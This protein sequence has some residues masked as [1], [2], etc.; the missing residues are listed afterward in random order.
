MWPTKRQGEQIARWRQVRLDRDCFDLSLSW[1]RCSTRSEALSLGRARPPVRCLA[2]YQA[3]DPSQ[4]VFV[5]SRSASPRPSKS[6]DVPSSEAVTTLKSAALTRWSKEPSMTPASTTSRPTTRT[7]S[8]Q[9]CCKPRAGQHRR[10]KSARSARA[11]RAAPGCAP[12]VCP[13]RALTSHRC[14][15]GYEHK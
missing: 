6:H 5:R 14:E 13:Y 1:F 15:S 8:W 7:P 2:I 10:T 3:D 4:L 11:L 9:V 12:R